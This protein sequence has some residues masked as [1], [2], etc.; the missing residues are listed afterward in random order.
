VDTG[1][2]SKQQPSPDHPRIDHE[3]HRFLD[4]HY[5]GAERIKDRTVLTMLDMEEMRTRQCIHHLKM[6]NCTYEFCKRE[7]SKLCIEY[8]HQFSGRKDWSEKYKENLGNGHGQNADL[9]SLLKSLNAL[10]TEPP[11]PPPTLAVGPDRDRAGQKD[12]RPEHHMRNSHEAK[13]MLTEFYGYHN[14]EIRTMNTVKYHSKKCVMA[15]LTSDGKAGFFIF[16]WKLMTPED[17]AYFKRQMEKICEFEK[18]D[19]CVDIQDEA[20]RAVIFY[21][22]SILDPLVRKS[23]TPREV[24]SPWDQVLHVLHNPSTGTDYYK[25]F[26]AEAYDK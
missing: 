12:L 16:G 21:L 25:N 10:G 7:W 19:F 8:D 23:Y 22:L 18:G 15:L 9:H 13:V 6:C 5:F 1:A 17:R 11:G 2:T 4:T 20:E 24:E 3:L 26:Q 14:D